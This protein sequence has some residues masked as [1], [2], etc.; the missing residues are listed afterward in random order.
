MHQLVH[1]FHIFIIPMVSPEAVYN[2]QDKSSYYEYKPNP[3]KTGEEIEILTSKHVR[4]DFGVL[5]KG[6]EP[7]DLKCFQTNGALIL[8][9]L[10]QRHT[11]AAMLDLKDGESNRIVYPFGYEAKTESARDLEG[12]APAG[13]GAAKEGVSTGESKDAKET[14]VETPVEGAGQEPRKPDATE[15]Q[16][17]TTVDQ[18]TD[19]K[20]GTAD[21][22]QSPKTPNPQNND[23]SNSSTDETNSEL[24]PQD[25]ESVNPDDSQ[26]PLEPLPGTNPDP[27]DGTSNAETNTN[28]N[29]QNNSEVHDN[30][31][32]QNVE[33][34]KDSTKNTKGETSNGQKINLADWGL[35]PIKW[36]NYDRNWENI[37]QIIGKNYFKAYFE[38]KVTNDDIFFKSFGDHLVKAADE[39]PKVSELKGFV[40]GISRE[41]DSKYRQGKMFFNQLIGRFWYCREIDVSE[42]KKFILLSG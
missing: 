12:D 8:L 9:Q 23:N 3:K 35:T 36:D 14:T 11:F 1:N 2:S 41:Y 38:Q 30:Q 29:P 37:N 15:G 24:N 34:E 22:T 26:V 13:E 10:M 27:K 32:S 5:N 6:E 39:N 40:H 25:P 31:D 21:S 28:T 33:N 18:Q 19:V 20:S 7:K 16:S 17:D 4:M 42:I